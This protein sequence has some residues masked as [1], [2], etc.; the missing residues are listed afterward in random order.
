M[1]KDFF[2]AVGRF[3]LLFLL[4]PIALLCGA[5]I[6]SV[7]SVVFGWRVDGLTSNGL[8]SRLEGDIRRDY[9]WLFDEYKATVLPAKPLSAG[10]GLR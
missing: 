6:S 3:F 7:Y 2:G 5:L 10:L 1:V 4:R 8:R 9:L